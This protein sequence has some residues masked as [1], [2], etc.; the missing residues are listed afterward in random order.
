MPHIIV[1]GAGITGVTTAYA[2]ARARLRRHRLR[3]ASLCGM[4]TSFANGGQLSASNA[5]VWNHCV[6]HSQGHVLD[7]AKGR[8]AAVQP[9][10]QLAQV[11]LDGGV[12][13]A[14]SRITGATRSRPR[15]WRS[16]A[17]KHLFDIAE[18]E[19]ID[20]DHERRGILHFYRDQEG[21]RACDARQRAAAGRRARPACRDARGDPGDRAGAA[22]DLLRRLLHALRCHRR[23]PQVHARPGACLRTAGCKVH[24]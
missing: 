20:F 18:R 7:D 17:R 21:L 9:E 23:H 14:R 8:A 6:D 13:R 22:R 24:L 5:E 3:P 19:G 16:Q 12:R 1:I 10:A 11:F 4:E 2:L 15:G